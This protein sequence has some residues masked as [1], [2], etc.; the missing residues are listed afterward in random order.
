VDN[1]DS[2]HAIRV[3]ARGR[4]DLFEHEAQQAMALAPYDAEI[5]ATLG[6]M[7]ADTGQWQRGVALVKKAHALNAHAAVGWYEGTMYYDYYLKGEYERALE[8]RRQHPDQQALHAYI[9]Y[10]PVYGQLGRKQEALEN[11][12]K[13]LEEDQDWSVESFEAWYRLWNFRDREI[14]KLMDGIYKSGVLEVDVTPKR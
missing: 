9:E 2:L 10:I 12:R 4:L 6:A 11:W 13:L 3:L 7:I 5:L 8:F 1:A 14:V